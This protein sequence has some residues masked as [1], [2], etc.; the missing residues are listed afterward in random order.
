MRTDAAPGRKGR[1]DGYSI[2]SCHSVPVE[3]PVESPVESRRMLKVR[4]AA[5]RVPFSQL[6]LFRMSKLQQRLRAL[7]KPRLPPCCMSREDVKQRST[8]KVRLSFPRP[9]PITFFQI[10]GCSRTTLR[11]PPVSRSRSRSRSATPSLHAN[12]GASRV[13][14]CS[15]WSLHEVRL[16]VLLG[17]RSKRRT[18]RSVAHRTSS[19]AHRTSAIARNVT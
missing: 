13:T 6:Q 12:R 8:G 11:T 9:S 15:I 7:R 5:P 18:C 4:I 3:V 2:G 14:S 1:L 10:P 17:P 19:I 16:L